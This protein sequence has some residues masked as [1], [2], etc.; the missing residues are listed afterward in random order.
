MK[1]SLIFRLFIYAFGV[2][3][4]S[5][6]FEKIVTW[7]NCGMRKSLIYRFFVYAF[8]VESFSQK[9]EKI[10]KWKQKTTQSVIR[11]YVL[12]LYFFIKGNALVL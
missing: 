8:R 5:Q 2:K 6:K 1:K 9:F 3:L 10:I 12:S 4:F 7:T 11:L